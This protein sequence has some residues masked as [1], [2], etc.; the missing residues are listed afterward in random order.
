MKMIRAS[1]APITRAACTKSRSLSE[2]KSAR[3]RRVIPIQPVAPM[4]IMMFQIEG[5][6]KAITA[7][8]RK[9]VG[10]HSMM[11]TK[12]MMTASTHRP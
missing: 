4:M 9:N 8:M 11:S 5:S 6:R 12:R 2:M 3:T 10:K 7:R 1:L